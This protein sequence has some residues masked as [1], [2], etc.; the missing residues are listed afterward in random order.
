MTI[1]STYRCRLAAFVLVASACFAGTGCSHAPWNTQVPQRE[2]ATTSDGVA[3]VSV[4]AGSFTFAETPEW[5]KAVKAPEKGTVAPRYTPLL[6][7]QYRFD[8]KGN[9]EKYVR[10]IVAGTDIATLQKEGQQSIQFDPRYQKVTVH[11]VGIW[12]DGQRIDMT[13]NIKPRFLSDDRAQNTIFSGK[14]NALIQVPDF[15]AGDHLEFAWTLSGANPVY[16][17]T[18]WMFEEWLKPFPVW[19]RHLAYLWPK[20]AALRPNLVPHVVSEESR[21]SRIKSTY[22]VRN[23]KVSIEYTDT[24][25]PAFVIQ[26]NA[27]QGSVQSDLL[28]ASGFS[29]WNAVS[30]WAEQL[31]DRVEAPKGEAYLKLVEEFRKLPSQPEQIAAALQWVQRE[32]RYVSLSIGE[33]SHR[34]YSPD[35]VIARRYGDCKDTALLLA[36]LLRSLGMESR[37]ALVNT[38]NTRLTRQMDAIPW[39]NHAIAL[40]WLDGQVYALDGTARGQKSRLEHISELYAGSDVLV[41]GGNSPGFL[42]IPFAGA[43]D[44][45]T[46]RQEE[47]MKIDPETQEGTL[48]SLLVVRGVAAERKRNELAAKERAEIKRNMLSD[49]QQHHANARWQEGPEITDNTETNEISIRSVFRIP[50]PLKRSGRNWRNEYGNAIV[51][52]RLPKIGNAERKVPVGLDLGIQRAVLTYTLDVPANYCIEEEAHEETIAS[53]GFSA[54][55][56]RRRPSATRLVDRQELTLLKDTVERAEI[57]A[58]QQATQELVDFRPEIRIAKTQKALC[59]KKQDDRVHSVR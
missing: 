54:T 27:A 59:S 43:I 39:F 2:S 35:E 6:D 8:D 56:Q 45:R 5:V 18:P 48:T 32:I 4:P 17:D 13:E 46:V 49:V 36:Y 28:V 1:A 33:N 21:A 20:N 16:G 57:P 34:P 7:T 41:I 22:R 58:Y 38:Q 53:S 12:R 11:T 50:Q 40:V 3:D 42:R 30:A 55:I 10:I 24:N 29:D 25:L 31:F 37:P 15:R 47:H 23:G 9:I 19:K 44:G 26:K 14:V 51:V 52:S